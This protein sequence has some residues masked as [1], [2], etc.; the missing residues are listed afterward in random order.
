VPVSSKELANTKQVV[1]IGGGLAGMTVAL[2]VAKGFERAGRQVRIR[3]LERSKRVGGKAGADVYYGQ[4]RTDAAPDETTHR[5]MEDHGFHIF[6]AWYL[7]TRRLL[8]EVG[9]TSN[10]I[11]LDRF[12]HLHRGKFPQ[13]ITLKQWTPGNVLA[14]AFSGLAPLP[15]CFLSFYFLA[16]LCAQPFSRRA[17]LDRVS[18]AGFLRSRFYA[19]DAIARLHHQGSL[20]ASSIPYYEISA[21]TLQRMV[22]G[23]FRKPVPFVSILNGDLQTK[24]IEPFRR[25]LEQRHGVEVLEDHNVVRL[26]VDKSRDAASAKIRDLM[27]VNKPGQQSIMADQVADGRRRSADDSA[28]ASA[29]IECDAEAVYVLA[30]PIDEALELVDDE[31]YG[32]ECRLFRAG[33]SADGIDDRHG[34]ADLIQ[35]HSAPMAAFHVHFRRRIPGV[36][37]EHTTCAGS[38]YGLTFVDVSQYWPDLPNTTL[39]CI[40][41]YYLP[42]VNV[43]IGTAKLMLLRDLLQYIPFTP[44]DIG[45][46]CTRDDLDDEAL[47]ELD[48]R[49]HLA[50]HEKEQLFLNTV[51][52]WHYRPDGVTGFPNL[53]VTGDY[54]RSSA[55]LT[56]MESAVGSAYRT[57][58]HVLRSFDIAPGPDELPVP[59]PPLWLMKA[60]KWGALPFVV[61]TWLWIKVRDMRPGIGARS[62][63]EA[64]LESTP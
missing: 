11:D 45:F 43:E 3:I 41:S 2:E 61:L 31:V 5:Y 21:M 8:E 40:A 48:L 20:Q 63:T 55:D 56:T 28:N 23:W 9:C 62:T 39:N 36:P 54:C 16:D 53:F 59:E 12:H 4:Y 6:P 37:A 47:R 64:G 38:E 7:N 15:E 17:Y 18:A 51:G 22:R 58:Q 35:L 42:M 29:L 46:D 1:V 19:S 52:A 44:D 25:C 26:M 10:L 30:V 27:V 34:L 24:F 14:N 33:R 32:A 49:C 57:A 13:A 60:I 50:T